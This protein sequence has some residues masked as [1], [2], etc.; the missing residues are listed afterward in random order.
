MIS[1]AILFSIALFSPDS[2]ESDVKAPAILIDAASLDTR[3]KS[4]KLR[5]LELHPR[6][7]AFVTTTPLSFT[8]SSSPRQVIS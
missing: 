4:E 3:M 2:K 5:I 6:I 1:P 8:V 7:Q